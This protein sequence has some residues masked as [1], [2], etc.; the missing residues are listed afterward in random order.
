MTARV[1]AARA[2]AEAV[3]AARPIEERLAADLSLRDARV[4]PRDRALARSIATVA[5]RRLGT[6]RKALAQRLEK[7][8]PRRSGAME[9]TLV[10]GAAQLLFMETPDHAAVDLAV[11]ATR[12]DAASVPFAGLVNA[13]LR[14][15]ARDRAPSSPP[16][17]RSTTTRRP[18]SPP[19]GARL[20]GDDAARSIAAAQQVRADPRPQREE[21]SCRQWAERLGGIVLPT[22]SVRLDTH[23]P[24]RRARRLC[25]R[26]VVGAGR[27]RCAAGAAPRRRAPDSGS[28]TSAPRPAAR[29]PSSLSPAPKSPRSTAPRSG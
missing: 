3:T 15:V 12:A 1:A 14:A 5:L 19:A 23:R 16:R 13:V 20:Y 28:S 21:R 9:W 18:G 17:T 8:M 2:V 6:I 26:R 11:R 10:V 7:G 4:D 27:R 24:D 22:G 25:G 29:A